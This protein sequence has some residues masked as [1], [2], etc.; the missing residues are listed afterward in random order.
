MVGNRERY[1]KKKREAKGRGERERGRRGRDRGTK[2]EGKKLGVGR[3]CSAGGCTARLCPHS[4]NVLAGKREKVWCSEI[5]R[6]LGVGVPLSA[7]QLLQP[8]H[9]MGAGGLWASPA[10]SLCPFMS[11]R[12]TS[13]P[14]HCWLQGG[15]KAPKPI[16]LSPIQRNPETQ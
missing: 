10:P 16:F 3:L 7:G 11:E 6:G 2:A 4:S 8:T 13:S 15:S 9:P 12:K 5:R 1:R 14:E